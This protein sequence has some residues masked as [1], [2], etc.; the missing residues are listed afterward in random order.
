MKILLEIAHEEYAELTGAQKRGLAEL[1]QLETV[2]AMTDKVETVTAEEV[3][4]PKKS[5][6][7]TK[8]ADVPAETETPATHNTE[9]VNNTLPENNTTEQVE[10]ATPV[11]PEQEAPAESEQIAEQEAP[12]ESP[13]PTIEEIMAAG[14]KF[15]TSNPTKIAEL[16]AVF[17]EFGIKQ[18]T[19]LKAT[20]EKIPA[21]VDAIKAVGVTF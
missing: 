5:S 11:A 1:M 7:K 14:S 4:K 9:E 15:I 2:K 8:K 6:R 16:Q 18:I 13:V 19:G 20:P 12:A 10:V 21:F 17:A 3:A